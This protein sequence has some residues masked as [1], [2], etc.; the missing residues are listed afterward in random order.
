MR[1]QN[2]HANLCYPTVLTRTLF[3]IGFNALSFQI[4][5]A[6]QFLTLLLK[7]PSQL[8][9][10]VLKPGEEVYLI[11]NWFPTLAPTSLRLPDKTS[12]Y[13]VPIKIRVIDGE[14]DE[15]ETGFCTE[16]SKRHT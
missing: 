4:R 2:Y 16:D 6:T 7:N 10:F 13:D 1:I 11:H 15:F 9:I 5:A 12:M 8:V 14:M 3:K